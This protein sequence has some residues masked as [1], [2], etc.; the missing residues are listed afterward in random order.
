[1]SEAAAVAQAELGG[2]G[3]VNSVAVGVDG[4]LVGDGVGD[5]IVTKH[6]QQAGGCAPGVPVEVTGAAGGV[7]VSPEATLP[8]GAVAGVLIV[9]GGFV[10]LKLGGLKEFGFDCLVDRG[11]VAGGG[12]GPGV[13][14]LAP[15]VGSVSSSEALGLAVVG[16]VVLVFVGDDLGCESGGD[17]GAGDG[18]KRGGRDDGGPSL[19]GLVDE[20]LADGAPPEDLG[21]DDVELVVV[22]LADFVPVVGIGEDFVGDGDAMDEDFKVF[23][24]TVR[25]GAAGFY[26]V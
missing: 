5:L 8:D 14:G 2:D 21:L 10:D 9:D 23:R 26:G 22:F 20:F 13:E 1:M 17:Q 11:E 19:V 24:K 25:L 15:D 4:A 16:K 6:F 12:V 3:V 18:G 7:A